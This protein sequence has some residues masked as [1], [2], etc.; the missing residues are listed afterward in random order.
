MISY[1]IM[2]TFS[3]IYRIKRKSLTLE[4][5]FKY[6]IGESETQFVKCFIQQSS[7]PAAELS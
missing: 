3:F 6:P 1:R 4:I 7:R 5:A 2:L